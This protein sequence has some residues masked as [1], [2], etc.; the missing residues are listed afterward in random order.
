MVVKEGKMGPADLIPKLGKKVKDV[1]FIIKHP[2]GW[3]I[4]DLGG[5]GE[6]LKKSLDTFL[7]V[8]V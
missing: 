6:V 1:P 3:G 4:L 2:E 8:P 5:W 7:N